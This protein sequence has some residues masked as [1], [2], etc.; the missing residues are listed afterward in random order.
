ML[1]FQ[2]LEPQIPNHQTQNIEIE[3]INT[4]IYQHFADIF[5]EAELHQLHS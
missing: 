5:C 3:H 1:D 4:Q 2:P